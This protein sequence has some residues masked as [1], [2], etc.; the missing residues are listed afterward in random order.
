M[1]ILRIV[2]SGYEQ[3]GVENGLVFTNRILRGRG[4]DV[5]T[6]SS[7]ARPDRP[8]YSDYEFREIPTGGIRRLLKT[9]FNA[10]A[11][12]LAKR[13]ALEFQP[14]IITLHTLYQPSV[15]VL[16]ALRKYRLV[17]CVHGPEA[18]TNW[19]MPWNLPTDDYR[20]RTYDLSDLT[21]RGKA[22]LVY[23]RYVLRPLYLIRLRHVPNIISYSHYT[24]EMLLL[25]GLHSHYIP[26]GI[27]QFPQKPVRKPGAV[28]GF[29]GRLQKHKGIGYLIDVMS[30]VIAKRPAA[31]FRIAGEGPYRSE[32][33]QQVDQLGLRDHVAFIGHLSR[34]EM[35]EFYHSID[36]FVMASS[37]AET[38]GKVGVE[39]MSSGTPVIAPPIGGIPDWLHDGENGYFAPLD[40]E[41]E[42]ASVIL[43][44]LES[45]ETL[46]RLGEN[47]RATAAKFTME[48][49][50]R[51]HED[52]FSWILNEGS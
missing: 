16:W 5:R 18:Y 7:N 23:F 34:D 3:G 8:H 38:F 48:R 33:L 30:R 22:H 47:A 43:R 35:Q 32:L 19:L 25:E 29:A 39:A 51:L 14:D 2:S 26:Q 11:Y 46:E 49:Y 15:S 1:R 21:L 10:E 9:T 52:Y 41:A 45:A 37:P 28:V 24:Q 50:A 20:E 42:Y 31:T 44:A 12:R 13:V 4:H 40:D 27:E 36:V 17:V 6:I